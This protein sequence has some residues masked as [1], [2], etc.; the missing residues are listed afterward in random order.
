MQDADAS[1]ISA[2]Y[3][4]VRNCL[5]GARATGLLE[6]QQLP[7]AVRGGSRRQVAERDPLRGVP[8]GRS[9]R[10]Q[11]RA[12]VDAGPPVRQD[13]VRPRSTPG[14][15]QDPGSVRAVPRG[16]RAGGSSQRAADEPMFYLPRAPRGVESRRVR[17]MPRGTGSRS[18]LAAVVP[19]PRGWL[20]APARSACRARTALVPGMPRASGV[21]RLPRHL[22]AF[23]RR[24]TARRKRSAKFRASRRLH[25]SA[26][27]RGASTRSELCALSRAR[28][29]RR[30][31]RRA[32][33]ERKPPERPQSAPSGMGRHGHASSK[34][35][36]SRSAPRHPALRRLSRAGAGHELHSLSSCGRLRWQSAPRRLE[37][38]ARAER[39][40]V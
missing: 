5:R 37:E 10:A 17:A 22:S 28:D 38:C 9:G 36:R 30:L 19:A 34:L 2:S 27:D 26:R 40:N 14:H 12:R 1:A 33:R 11:D 7:H 25:C 16:R 4:L 6:L 23:R 21:Q 3:A 13:R 24:A 20:H 15:A 29:V 18:H 32:R 39:A 35:S 8:Q 31:P